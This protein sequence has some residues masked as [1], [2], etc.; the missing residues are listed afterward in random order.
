MFDN[1]NPVQAAAD[2]Y[3]QKTFVVTFAGVKRKAGSAPIGIVEFES[4]NAKGTSKFKLV[5]EE[6]LA[7]E[8]K[9]EEHYELTLKMVKA[10]P[11]SY[12]TGK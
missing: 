7:N 8:Y 12:D 6:T 1:E 5:G 11:Q 3:E 4:A 10:K 2:A 9:V